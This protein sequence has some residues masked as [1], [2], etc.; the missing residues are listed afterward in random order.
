MTD[1]PQVI[2][3]SILSYL[4]KDFNSEKEIKD[5]SINVFSKELSNKSVFDLAVLKSQYEKFTLNALMFLK[6]DYLV[7]TTDNVNFSITTKGFIKL[8]TEN[9]TQEIKNKKVNL[10]LQRLTW[11]CAICALFVSLYTCSKK[12]TY[13]SNMILHRTCKF[14]GCEVHNGNK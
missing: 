2:L 3:D 13:P 9:F 1:K 4:A 8:K 10:L 5:I 12:E 6:S 7:N 11:I 14:Q